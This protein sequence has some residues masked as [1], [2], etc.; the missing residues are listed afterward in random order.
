M[1]K[2]RQY[3]HFIVTLRLLFKPEILSFVYCKILFFVWTRYFS[4]KKDQKYFRMQVLFQVTDLGL[5]AADLHGTKT[6]Q[7]VI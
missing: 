2:S 1:E 7:L 3:A 5:Y 6:I 4:I